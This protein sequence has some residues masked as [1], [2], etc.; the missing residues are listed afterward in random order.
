MIK[1]YQTILD[2]LAKQ[3]ENPNLTEESRKSITGDMIVVAD[4]IAMADEKNK[5]FFIDAIGKIGFAIGSVVLILGTAIGINAKFGQTT[6]LPQLGDD[7]PDDDD[8]K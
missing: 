6:D 5:K 1:G 2:A 4:K 7:D 3:L 8:H